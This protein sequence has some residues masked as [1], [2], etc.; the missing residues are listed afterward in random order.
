MSDSE[1]AALEARL[2][3]IGDE[4][5]LLRDVYG[6]DHPKTQNRVMEFRRL[7][8]HYEHMEDQRHALAAQAV[9][10]RADVHSE[11]QGHRSET[12]GVL[13]HELP[14][15]QGTSKDQSHLGQSEEEDVGF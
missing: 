2:L 11:V 14:K 3:A 5:W 7:L 13:Q 6:E 1:I 15:V 4:Y 8:K 12:T 10:V 9:S